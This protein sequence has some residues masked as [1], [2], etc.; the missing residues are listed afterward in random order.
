VEPFTLIGATTRLGN[1]TSPLRDRFGVI[2][3]VD[4]YNADDLYY[5]IQR[6]AEIL[7]VDID[8]GGTKELSCRSRGT[9]R[10]ANRILR[11]ARDYAEVKANGKIDK[12]VAKEALDG[13]G[14]DIHG[15]D[16]MDRRIL[17]ALIDKFNGG[18]V[19]VS[20][21]SVAVSE[22]ASTIE[23]V[24]EPYL[25]KEGFIQRTSRGRIAQEK[26]FKLL[27]RTFNSK[28]QQRLFK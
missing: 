26:A 19:G 3:R 17:T 10:I 22:D 8:D 27:N 23:D 20:S 14:I 28:I 25:I 9:P 6:S 18:P 5:I 4:F 21:L 24:Y 15:L 11:R 2:L 12:D 1:L 7:E 13:M 16:D